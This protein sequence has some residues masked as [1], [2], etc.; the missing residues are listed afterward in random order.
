MSAAP[1][2]TRP[3]K[4]PAAAPAIAAVTV[5]AS[6]TVH[7]ED[8]AGNTGQHASGFTSVG[9]QHGERAH[10]TATHRK[11]Q[12]LGILGNGDRA[13]RLLERIADHALLCGDI[14]HPD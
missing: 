7:A 6:E 14:E 5:C 10:R 13:G 11:Q 2:S 9:D 3:M 1:R 4:T 12:W 8:A